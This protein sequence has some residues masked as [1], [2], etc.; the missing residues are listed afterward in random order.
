[1]LLMLRTYSRW[2]IQRDLQGVDGSFRSLASRVATKLL[3]LADKYGQ[4][5]EHGVE[6]SIRVTEATLAN[7]IGA[8]RENVSRAIA[9]LRRAGDVRRERGRILL[10]RPDEMRVRYSWVTEEE[11]RVITAKERARSKSP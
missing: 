7:M 9:Q 8:S 2:I 5:S 4:H 6:V 11:A 1:M 3:H 10:P